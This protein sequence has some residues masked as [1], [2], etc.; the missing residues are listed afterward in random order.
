MIEFI[1]PTPRPIYRA[2]PGAEPIEPG[3]VEGAPIDGLQWLVNAPAVEAIV[4]DDRGFPAPMRCPDPRS[5]V[6]HKLWIA[7]RE[8]RDPVKKI[9]DIGQAEAVI[10]LLRERLPQH[11]FDAEFRAALPKPMAE[12]LEK[13]LERDT[14][15]APEKPAW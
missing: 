14:A 8:D 13:A 3:D 12:R 2:M 6:A 10:R 11:A 15:P 7:D 5:W 1:R 9:R 4:V